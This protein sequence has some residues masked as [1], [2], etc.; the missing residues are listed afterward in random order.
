MEMAKRCVSILELRY[1]SN[2]RRQNRNFAYK[3]YRYSTGA[4]KKTPGGAGT[5]RKNKTGPVQKLTGIIFSVRRIV[6][7]LGHVSRRRLPHEQN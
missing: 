5:H 4:G 7:T 2:Q 6:A 3:Q 1:R